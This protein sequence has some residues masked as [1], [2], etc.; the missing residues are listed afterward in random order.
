MNTTTS[1]RE[2][3]KQAAVEH[4]EWLR[5][6]GI[7][8]PTMTDFVSEAMLALVAAQRRRFRPRAAK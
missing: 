1:I 6:R 7:P 8:A 4:F 2:E 5:S 3:A